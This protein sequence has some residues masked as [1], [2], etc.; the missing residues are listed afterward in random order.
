MR[1]GTH[2]IFGINMNSIDNQIKMKM[3][4]GL[5]SSAVAGEADNVSTPYHICFVNTSVRK[6]H[7]S[8][9]NAATVVYPSRLTGNKL[10]AGE[11]DHT[12]VDSTDWGAQRGFIVESCMA[13][14]FGLIVRSHVAKIIPVGTRN[15]LHKRSIPTA[16][17]TALNNLFRGFEVVSHT[18]NQF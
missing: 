1:S 17:R 5:L 3:W 15:G 13:R 8:G 10:F 4:Q 14:M 12:V 7:V 11:G 9:E 6:M 2:K 18:C 16:R